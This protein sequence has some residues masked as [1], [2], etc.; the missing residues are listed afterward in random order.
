M[1]AVGNKEKGTRGLL[2]DDVTNW[3]LLGGVCLYFHWTQKDATAP[4]WQETRNK[5]VLFKLQLQTTCVQINKPGS[6]ATLLPEMQKQQN[7]I[8]YPATLKSALAAT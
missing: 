2:F 4:F 6:T 8:K 3:S 1:W 5:W 7:I